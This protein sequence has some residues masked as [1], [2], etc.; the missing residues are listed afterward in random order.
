MNGYS[1]LVIFL[2]V[3]ELALLLLVVLFFSRLRRSEDLLAKMQK[4]QDGLLKK[5]DFNAKLEQELVGSFRQRQAQ[6]AELDQQLEQ[7]RDELEKLVKKA[8]ECIRSPEFLRQII[9]NG[10]RRGQSPVA[11]AKATGLSREEVELILAQEKA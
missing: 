10:S 11:L 9:K 1:T 4:N 8:E 3:C 5:L 2:T 6:L 7:R